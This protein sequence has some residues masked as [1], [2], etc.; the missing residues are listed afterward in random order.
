MKTQ[1]ELVVISLTHWDREWRFP[2]EK[3]ACCWST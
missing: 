1:N 2:F 3:S